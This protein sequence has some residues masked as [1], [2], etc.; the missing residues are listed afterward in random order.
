MTMWDFYLAETI[1]C[2][3]N[4]ILLVL[5][6]V[7]LRLHKMGIFSIGFITLYTAVA[8]HYVFMPLY[9]LATGDPQ[10]SNPSFAS[11]LALVSLQLAGLLAGAIVTTRRRVPVLWR[12]PEVN[13]PIGFLV[14]IFAS[15]AVAYLGLRGALLGTLNPLTM[16]DVA[17]APEFRTY[18]MEFEL[19]YPTL[20]LEGV[21]Y[22]A[23]AMFVIRVYR[24]RST[25]GAFALAF[26]FT[27][28][29][30]L[31]LLATGSR[32]AFFTP[33]LIFLTLTNHFYRR[34]S[35]WLILALGVVAIPVF[36]ILRIASGGATLALTLS[37]ELV[38]DP[39]FILQEFLARFR[40]FDA[41]VDFLTWFRGQEFAL[42]RT[43]LEFPLRPIPRSLLPNKPS[44][45]DVF[46][47]YSIYGRPEFGGGVSI[48]GG[49][50]EMYYNYWVPGVLIWSFLLG[51]L[52][53]RAH[54]GLFE[55]M[56][57]ERL[58]ALAMVIANPIILRGLA[59]IGI[60]TSAT[61]QLLMFVA[62][63]ALVLSALL[64][65]NRFHERTRPTATQR[66]AG[67]GR[68]LHLP[69]R[70]RV[71]GAAEARSRLKGGD[72]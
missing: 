27:A 45:L 17:R 58:V 18:Y 60:S 64:V 53:Y 54:F 40:N 4:L 67:A 24:A 36:V 72:L 69:D 35:L 71:P 46:L 13:A 66:H 56:R 21:L 19:G 26:A 61:Q 57:S 25:V 32:S 55:L 2:I 8:P 3:L 42:G 30:A 48:F 43:I 29:T 68:V 47:S 28:L 59:T 10:V 6:S 50:V 20:I 15:A 65:F 12:V 41:I 39:Q 34:I 44:S 5:L 14:G 70:Q 9:M 31:V 37:S 23:L 33:L 51:S 49:A 1:I 52:I 7:R 63:Q 16:L 62:A 22:F 38:R 11:A